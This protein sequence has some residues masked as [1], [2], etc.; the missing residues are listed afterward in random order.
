MLGRDMGV[1]MGQHDFP[2][3][4]AGIADG[5]HVQ[6]NEMYSIV[7]HWNQLMVDAGAVR[8]T[9]PSVDG[10]TVEE[11]LRRDIDDYRRTRGRFYTVEQALSWYR[12]TETWQCLCDGDK[13]KKAG[14]RYNGGFG[15]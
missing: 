3:I 4:K 12:S 11:W 8:W 15:F 5:K 9:E 10:K 7:S 1:A 2:L 14:H 6:A 13:P